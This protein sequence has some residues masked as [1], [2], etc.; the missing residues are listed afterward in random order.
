MSGPLSSP[1]QSVS[2]EKVFVFPGRRVVS[3]RDAAAY[4]GLPEKRFRWI[5]RVR[6]G[7]PGIGADSYRI[8]DLDAWRG[9]MLLRTGIDD[10]GA[11][12]L[13]DAPD[14]VLDLVVREELRRIRVS[15]LGQIAIICG[16]VI[17]ALSH[18]PAWRLLRQALS[19]HFSTP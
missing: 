2:G 5:C 19:A 17:I 3:S 9:I 12:H 1:E 14:P 6:S 16:L 18:T 11:G 4:L 8:E 15:A 10:R 7:P 13:R